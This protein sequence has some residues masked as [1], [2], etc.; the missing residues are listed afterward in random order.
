MIVGLARSIQPVPPDIQRLLQ[1]SESNSYTM[2]APSLDE[3]EIPG[4]KSIIVPGRRACHGI[5]TTNILTFQARTPAPRI[6]APMLGRTVSISVSEWMGMR[7][8]N[9]L[10]CLWRLLACPGL[11]LFPWTNVPP[12]HSVASLHLFTYLKRIACLWG[13]KRHHA[14]VDMVARVPMFGHPSS[15]AFGATL[16]PVILHS[17]LQGFLSP[18][19]PLASLLIDH[20]RLSDYC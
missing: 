20:E 19:A 11:L 12:H 6:S 9:S 14:P 7:R 18:V 13:S 8:L 4:Y 10:H 16:L 5:G 17:H 15:Y 1:I 2:P 3:K